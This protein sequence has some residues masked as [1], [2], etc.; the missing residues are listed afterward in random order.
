MKIALKRISLGNY[1][2]AIALLPMVSIAVTLLILWLSVDHWDELRMKQRARRVAVHKVSQILPDGMSVSVLTASHV[3]TPATTSPQDIEKFRSLATDAVDAVEKSSSDAHTKDLAKKLAVAAANYQA[4]AMQLIWIDSIGGNDIAPIEVSRLQPLS[5][6]SVMRCPALLRDLLQSL[7]REIASDRSAIDFQRYLRWVAVAGLALTGVLSVGFVFLFSKQVNKRLAVLA[8]NAGNLAA[9]KPLTKPL[10]GGDEIASLDRNFHEM[11]H[12]LNS[13]RH[14]EQAAISNSADLICSLDDSFV[15][16]DVN[17]ACQ[18]ILGFNKE[19]ILG[20]SMLKLVMPSSEHTALSELNALKQTSDFKHFETQL[21][22]VQ[23]KPVEALWSGFYSQEDRFAFCIL[24]DISRR[25]EV[26]R[27]VREGEA[28]ERLLMERVPAALITFDE[29]G[30]ILGANGKASE[31]LSQP[32]LVG[33][34]LNACF[35]NEDVD[36][37][38]YAKDLCNKAA[39]Q[40]S[41]IAINRNGEQRTLQIS[42]AQLPEQAGKQ[43]L[44]VVL[45]QTERQQFKQM[46]ERFLS[47][48]AHD[49]ATPLTCIGGI[50]L[51]YSHGVYGQLTEN[52]TKKVEVAHA[53]SERL[54]RLFKDLLRAERD[55]E[56]QLAIGAS[57]IDLYALLEQAVA[58]VAEQAERAE[59]TIQIAGPRCQARVDPDRMAQVFVNLLTNAIKFSPPNST[60]SIELRLDDNAVRIQVADEGPGV[61]PEMQDAI[62]EPFR[63]VAVEDAT[64]RGG[65]GL[66]L[67][68]CKQIVTS[69]GGTISCANR[70]R[71]AC[72]TVSLPR[73]E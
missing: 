15:V 8:E 73:I 43:Y 34:S 35:G 72:F 62:F 40:V 39:N 47:M 61:P 54:A 56:I 70:Y 46:R 55:G 67:A 44:A 42:L 10:G 51:M 18:K 11:A 37:A 17:N 58:G 64:V 66:G 13:A 6:Q 3:T 26:E 38:S 20:G 1:I 60:V 21:M 59:V 29:T 25:K 71:G 24:H 65:S 4:S 33:K 5:I 9:G 50:F 7:D 68:I 48:I 52:G 36:S 31:I 63:Q 32:D 57:S 30:T 12:A 45:D 27:L 19:E 23:G 41:T 16:L 28:K 14:E 2:L 53:E 22:T 69:H 49:I